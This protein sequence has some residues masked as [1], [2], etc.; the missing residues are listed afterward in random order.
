M[1]NRIRPAGLVLTLM[2]IARL[3]LPYPNASARPATPGTTTVSP[4]CGAAA[5]AVAASPSPSISPRIRVA[6]PIPLDSPPLRTV[7]D[8]PLPGP[9]SRFDYQ[10]FDPTTGRLYIAHMAAGQLIV[11][12]TATGTVLGTVAD[13]PSITGVLVVPNLN[14]V[15]VAVAGDHQIAVVDT[16]SLTVTDRFGAIGFP[17][18]L[19]L[20]PHQQRIFVSDESGGG[21]VVIDMATNTVTATIDIGGDAGNT[22]YDAGS[23]C[24]LV[25]VQTRDQLVAID[26]ATARIVGRYDMGEKCQSPHGFLVDAPNRRAFVT[27]EDNAM[28]QVVDLT[29]MRVT[30]TLP[31]GD[32]PDVLAFDPGWC[33]LYVASESGTVSVFDEQGDKLQ[34][35]GTYQAPHAHS[36][37]VDPATHLVYL[38]L[39]NV[40]GQPV[41]RVMTPVPPTSHVSRAP[42]RP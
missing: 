9:A 5:T 17:D 34:S 8:V 26:P 13:L 33:R 31:T 42:R 41:L 29:T 28:M 14:R 38:P 35:D 10:S 36:V 30:A 20:A 12:D 24:M 16:R 7:R 1:G 32:G 19:D 22:H 2:M 18:G 3:A 25:T 40:A 15:Y 37:A 39:E 23:G 27:C 11:F 6:T 4:V 21:E